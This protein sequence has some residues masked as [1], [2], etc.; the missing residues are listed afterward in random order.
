MRSLNRVVLLGHLAADPDSRTTES[1]V[2]MV[3]FSV[4]TNR[5]W[6]ASDGQRKEAV[7]YHKF[8]AWRGLADVCAK[9]LVKGSPVYVEGR[10]QNSS[11]EDKEGVKRYSTEVV[12]ERL[13]VLVYKK[14]QIGI[15]EMSPDDVAE[16]GERAQ[17]KIEEQPKKEAKVEEKE[18][19]AA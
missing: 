4:A 3:I 11:Y 10:L 15:I 9:H 1:G 2:P 12:L 5:D 16:A 6:K 8:V 14:K 17:G 7:D 19:V 13:H 18:A